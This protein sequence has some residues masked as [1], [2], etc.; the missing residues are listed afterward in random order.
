MAGHVAPEA[1]KGGPIAAVKN[2]DHHLRYRQAALGR[3]PDTD[4]DQSAL[5]ESKDA[6]AAL[7]DGRD[8]QICSA[9][10]SASEGA[11]TT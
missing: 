5:K 8:G 9:V 3:R 4:R 6:R 7:H 10:S 2:G 1:I 11:I